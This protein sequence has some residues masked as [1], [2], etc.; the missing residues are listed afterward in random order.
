MEMREIPIEI[1][2]TKHLVTGEDVIQ[3]SKDGGIVAT[4][5]PR[6]GEI[7][8]V[9][10]YIENVVKDMAYPAKITIQLQES[11]SNN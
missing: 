2:I 6:D 4:V 10:K 9:S 7:V 11:G 8:V 3:I 5:I 1:K